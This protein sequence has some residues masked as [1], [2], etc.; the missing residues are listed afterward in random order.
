MTTK[1]MNFLTMVWFL[2]TLIC[3]VVEGTY[4]GTTENNIIN[5]LS[6]MTTMNI[7]GV[8]T[9][10]VVNPEFFIGIGR[11]L[12]W[13]YSFYQGGYT[14]IRYFWLCTL[15]PGVLW[16]LYSLFAPVIANFIKF[17]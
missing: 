6:I 5:Q 13:D 12:L 2:S 1:F 17:W 9:I 3:L 15:T 14:I 4:L 11:I 7:G 10:T 16:G 8:A